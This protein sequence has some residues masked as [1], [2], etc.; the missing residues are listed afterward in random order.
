[1]DNFYEYFLLS[2]DYLLSELDQLDVTLV[3]N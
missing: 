2:W 3:E 1:M